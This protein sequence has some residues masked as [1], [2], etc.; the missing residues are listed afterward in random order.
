MFSCKFF[1][2]HDLSFVV[3]PV[4][5]VT[6]SDINSFNRPFDVSPYRSLSFHLSWNWNTFMGTN[7]FEHA[8]F[9]FEEFPLCRPQ[10]VIQ[11]SV[12]TVPD[13][14]RT[15]LFHRVNT[16][17]GQVF[18][19]FPRVNSWNRTNIS[20]VPNSSVPRKRSLSNFTTN[21]FI[22]QGHRSMTR[23]D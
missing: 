1:K 14:Y 6:S 23:P 15:V 8:E 12:Y 20:L 19:L 18:I 9:K 11:D 16:K 3:R 10:N 22:V 7:T 13:E 17:A 4:L 5:V 21:F 2:S